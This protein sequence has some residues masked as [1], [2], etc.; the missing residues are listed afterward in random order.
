ML[1]RQV[2][3]FFLPR[4]TE[5]EGWICRATQSSHVSDCKRGHSLIMEPES[6]ILLQPL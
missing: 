1:G 4:T 2:L 3:L 6:Q 5:S